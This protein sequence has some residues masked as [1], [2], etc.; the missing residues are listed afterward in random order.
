MRRRKYITLV[1]LGIVALSSLVNIVPA[2]EKEST[3]VSVEEP[4]LALLQINL[5]D[6]YKH[7]IWGDLIVE[8]E[9]GNELEVREV[10]EGVFYVEIPYSQK[11]IGLH[12]FAKHLDK[13]KHQVIQ[14]LEVSQELVININFRSRAYYRRAK[15][16]F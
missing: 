4:S 9:M 16:K 14:I 12:I 3:K 2:Q 11:G 5:L 13:K 15:V 10:D 7:P 6:Q 1:L 8:G